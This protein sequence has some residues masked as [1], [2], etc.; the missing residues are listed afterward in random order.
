MIGYKSEVLL[1]SPILNYLTL[2][3]L[4]STIETHLFALLV[5]IAMSLGRHLKSSGQ[6]K[7]PFSMG[8]WRRK[9]VQEVSD[10]CFFFPT[11]Q[12]SGSVRLVCQGMTVKR[13]MAGEVDQADKGQTSPQ[14][15]E[16]NAFPGTAPCFTHTCMLTHIHHS[17]LMPR[18]TYFVPVRMS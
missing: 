11:V 3:S 1:N 2:Y 9:R 13:R 15:L 6:L 4:Q 14:K 18:L 17:S 10:K 5:L 7:H 16:I 12:H 8:F